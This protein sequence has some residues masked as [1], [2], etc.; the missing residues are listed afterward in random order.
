MQKA[1]RRNRPR[2]SL[3]LQLAGHA[4][5][6]TALGLGFCLLL[7]LTGNPDLINMIAYNPEPKTTALMLISFVALTFAAG[8]TLTGMVLMTLEE[9]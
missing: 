9:T 5:M 2:R 7:A 4:A 1:P 3:P 8:A 6:G